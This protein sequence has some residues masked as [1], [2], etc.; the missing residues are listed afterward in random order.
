MRT[1][2]SPAL[3]GT[4]DWLRSISV[5]FAPGPVNALLEETMDELLSAF[6]RLGHRVQDEPDADTDTIFTTVRYNEGLNWRE[7]LMFTARRKFGLQH[8]P[9]VYSVMNMTPAQYEAALTHFEVVLQKDEPD[10]EDFAFPGLGPHAHHTLF[11]QGK[12]GGPI[13]ALLRVLQTQV[14]SIHILLVVGKDEIE[15]A[16][17]FDLVGA[18]PKIEASDRD[19]FFNDLVLRIATTNSTHEI[20]EH[21]VIEP[22]I[23]Y[24]QWQRLTT[25]TAMKKT[26]RLLGDRD[27][28]TD[29]IR[30]ADLASVPAIADAI[31][32]QYS[33]GCFAT[34]DPEIGALVTT[35]TGSAR[36]VEKDTI[37]EADLAVIAGVR[38][39][40]LGAQV[41]EVD[42]KHNDPP[43]SEAVELYDMDANLPR[44]RLSPPAWG[45]EAEVPVARSKLHGHRGV[46]AYDPDRVEF[47][48][49]DA[50]YYAYPVSCATE[51]QARGIKAAFSRAESLRN[52][53]DPRQVAFTVLPGHGLVIVEKWVPGNAP[54][55]KIIELMDSGQL[56][57]ANLIPQG[58]M[59]YLRGTDGRMV[60]EE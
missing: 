53:D 39:D 21:K 52:P 40:G 23:P 46:S 4:H 47:V 37:T 48:R 32:S 43:S 44:V 9:T 42:G 3:Q 14:K 26:S 13:M 8:T 22:P 15:F 36:P 6:D 60:L 29:M 20:T 59:V 28:F 11:E 5:T 34:W 17:L 10:P 18:H 33:E 2:I 31:S 58:E 54:F 57:I 16:H 56:E 12:R 45:A 51:A 1:K 24:E 49:L 41:R 30:I 7:A 55:E 38:P 19:E 50:P 35:I 27:F 25:P